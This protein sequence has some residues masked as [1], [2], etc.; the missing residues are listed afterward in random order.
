MAKWRVFGKRRNGKRRLL[1]KL[2]FKNKAK[3]FKIRNWKRKHGNKN[4]IIGEVKIVNARPG[5]ASVVGPVLSRPKWSPARDRI[6]QEASTRG[7]SHT[8]GDRSHN[9]LAP[10]GRMSDHW[11]AVASS[12]A[13]DYWHS[14]VAEMEK[15]AEWC[16]KQD[17]IKQCLVH[18]AGSGNHVHVA[19][20]TQRQ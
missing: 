15:F 14:S 3:A 7:L 19:G 18:D 17:G 5:T 9:T 13:D 20:W 6:R 10:V 11:S 12:W 8:S 1:S 4:A 16:K 2:T